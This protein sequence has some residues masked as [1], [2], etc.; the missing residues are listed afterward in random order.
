MLE[1]IRVNTLAVIRGHYLRKDSNISG[2]KI[3][4]WGPF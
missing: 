2:K 3:L 1:L 4:S